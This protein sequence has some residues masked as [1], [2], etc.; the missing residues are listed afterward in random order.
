MFW[1]L[2][3]SLVRCESF[4]M[5]LE[6][7]SR[8]ILPRDCRSLQWPDVRKLGGMMRIGKKYQLDNI[9][10]EALTRFKTQFPQT[11]A[12]RDFITARSTKF[13]EWTKDYFK[14]IT[15]LGEEMALWSI[16]PI[17]YYTVAS[18]S[19]NIVSR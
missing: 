17:A 14:D 5:G 9:F 13:Y 2:Y 7:F 18:N 16:L 15:D 1:V 4:I 6:C 10:E 19:K 3:I 12:A 11:V 8:L